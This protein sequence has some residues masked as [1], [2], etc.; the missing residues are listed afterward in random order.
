MA[1]RL[2]ALAAAVWT[3]CCLGVYVYL[4]TNPATG[5]GV[6]WWVVGL[7]V[8]AIAAAVLSALGLAARATAIV[9][10]VLVGGLAIVSLLSMGLLFLPGCGF[11]IAAAV[12]ARR[13]SV[14]QY[15]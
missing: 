15:R 6:A 9:C 1:H 11:A 8:I 12:L 7:L 2:L 14:R 5:S 4:V 10:A 3:A 13:R